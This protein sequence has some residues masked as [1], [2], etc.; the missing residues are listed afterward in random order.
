[1]APTRS[2]SD[3]RKFR[4]RGRGVIKKADRLNVLV[5]TIQS[6]VLFFDEQARK[7]WEYESRDGLIDEIASMTNVV[8]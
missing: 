2:D 1:M 7:V 8:S 4:D 6:A 5:P 3:D